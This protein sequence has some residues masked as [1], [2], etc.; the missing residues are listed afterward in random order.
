MPA[1]SFQIHDT[2]GNNGDMSGLVGGGHAGH[3]F[4]MPEM[5]SSSAASMNVDNGMGGVGVGGD[6]MPSNTGD[7]SYQFDEYLNFNAADLSGDL[8]VVDTGIFDYLNTALFNDDA[9]A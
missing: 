1:S 6:L 2:S 3:M 5:M 7:S 9:P 4:G 8:N